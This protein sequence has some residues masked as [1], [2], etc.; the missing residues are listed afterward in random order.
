M[1]VN[2]AGAVEA[3]QAIGNQM[4][5]LAFAQPPGGAIGPTDWKGALDIITYGSPEQV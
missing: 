4:E 1:D 3:V 2:I 5:R